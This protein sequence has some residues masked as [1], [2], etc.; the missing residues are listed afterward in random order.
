MDNEEVLE[1]E[2]V[3]QEPVAEPEPMTV[4]T[5][6][7]WVL[8]EDVINKTFEIGKTYHIKARGNCEFMISDKEPT[9]GIK[10]N[11]IT[12][13]KEQNANLWIKTGM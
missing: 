2:V 5:S 1:Q 6:G 10:T 11:E 4:A 12:F 13:K 3:E 9:V 8:L 7:N